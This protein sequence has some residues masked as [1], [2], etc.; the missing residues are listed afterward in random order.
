M[1]FKMKGLRSTVWQLQNSHEDVK[2]S[3]GDAV[4]NI[5]LTVYQG[6]HCGVK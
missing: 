6:D 4:N 1:I 5:V 3:I 2:Y